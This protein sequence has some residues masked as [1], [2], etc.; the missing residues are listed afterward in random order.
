ML[1]MGEA[2][3]SAS[4]SVSPQDP[5]FLNSFNAQQKIAI[6]QFLSQELGK[7]ATENEGNVLVNEAELKQF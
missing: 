3:L 2:A 5:A 7:S 4:L 6:Y 1:I